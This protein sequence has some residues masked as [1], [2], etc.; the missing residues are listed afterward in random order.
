MPPPSEQ[1]LSCFITISVVQSAAASRL[2]ATCSTQHGKAISLPS[3]THARSYLVDVIAGAATCPKAS[4]AG[5]GTWDWGLWRSPIYAVCIPGMVLHSA[6]DI[7]PASA[8]ARIRPQQ[9]PNLRS[10]READEAEATPMYPIATDSAKDTVPW[11]ATTTPWTIC[12]I[13][14]YFRR[15]LYSSNDI[16]HK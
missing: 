11:Q 3:A 1:R 7:H 13:A 10:R 6:V 9:V 12:T 5:L 4:V 8:S 14:V 15:P 16:G 2:T